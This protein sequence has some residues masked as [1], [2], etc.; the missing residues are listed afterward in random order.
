MKVIQSTESDIQT[1]SNNLIEDIDESILSLKTVYRRR[2][3]MAVSQTG[4][5]TKITS[6]DDL[7]ELPNEILGIIISY[8]DLKT[9]FRLRSTCKYFYEL[10]SDECLFKTLN[11]KPYWHLV[12]II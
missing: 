4:Q 5:L 9:I 6:C 7:T 2:S 12:S 11:L 8:L 1:D 10:C 3:S